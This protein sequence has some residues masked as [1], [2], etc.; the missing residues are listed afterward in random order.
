MKKVVNWV[1]D[2]DRLSF[3]GVTRD[4]MLGMV[5]HEK[6]KSDTQKAEIAEQRTG[7]AGGFVGA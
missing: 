3:Y 4:R 2:E 1:P 5:G 6:G 7:W